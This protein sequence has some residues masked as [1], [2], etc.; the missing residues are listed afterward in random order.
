MAFT[1]LPPGLTSHSAR[2]SN[3]RERA[4][5]RKTAETFEERL[6]SIEEHLGLNQNIKHSEKSLSS[7][8]DSAQEDC[9][10]LC[11]EADFY[12]IFS[13]AEGDTHCAAEDFKGTGKRDLIH[14][15]VGSEDV[16]GFGICSGTSKAC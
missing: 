5:V 13:E 7:T 3:R 9:R 11:R 6:R 12:D 8:T 16:L 10:S 15:P 2:R 14:V 4:A 1:P